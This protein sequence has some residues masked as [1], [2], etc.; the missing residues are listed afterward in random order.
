MGNSSPRGRTP[1][2]DPGMA[3]GAWQPPGPTEPFGFYSPLYS[4]VVW[5]IVPASCLYLAIPLH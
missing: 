3:L 4:F 5:L 1:L 2:C